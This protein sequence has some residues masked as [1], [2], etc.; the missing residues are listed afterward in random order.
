M[1][2]RAAGTLGKPDVI[3]RPLLERGQVS[4][5][6]ELVIDDGRQPPFPQLAHELGTAALR[7][8]RRRVIDNPRELHR[9]RRTADPEARSLERDRAGERRDRDLQYADEID[10]VRVERAAEVAIL[11]IDKASPVMLGH[12]AH[13]DR[14]VVGIGDVVPKRD[15]GVRKVDIALAIE[16]RIKGADKRTTRVVDS[17]CKP[18]FGV[19]AQ[20]VAQKMLPDQA[21]QRGHD[22]DEHE[23]EGHVAGGKAKA[24]A[25]RPEARPD[26]QREDERTDNPRWQREHKLQRADQ[27]SG[28]PQHWTWPQTTGGIARGTSVSAPLWR[29]W[30]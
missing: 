22:I 16:A 12:F 11:V 23:R 25:Q 28:K 2:R 17:G 3:G 13:R 18:A 14:L 26:G 19:V 5:A 7:G 8:A 27:Q 30:P 20:L 15:G 9:Q 24:M 29:F 1:Q 21:A 6:G 10:A 4:A